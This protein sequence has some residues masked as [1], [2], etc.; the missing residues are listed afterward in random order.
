[1]KDIGF[2]SKYNLLF[3]SAESYKSNEVKQFTGWVPIPPRNL[4]IVTLPSNITIRDGE[5]QLIPARIKSASGFSIDVANISVGL[6]NG[7]MGLGFNPSEV[8]V[9]I[10]RN[11]PALLKITVPEQTPIGIYTIP[12][13][14]TIRQPSVAVLTKPISINTKSGQMDLNSI[15]PK[16]YPTVG[17]I[18]RT[19]NLTITVVPPRTIGDQFRD[20]W[21][22]Y[23]GFITIIGIIVGGLVGAFATMMFE[24]R[25]KRMEIK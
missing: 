6:P 2:P 17:Y 15:I 21:G 19:V 7:E 25:K 8:Q 9:G 18:S 10:V 1:M 16:R 11:Q 4:R 24:R 12:L 13:N 23:G 3:Y 14:V 22:V 5:Q 20:F